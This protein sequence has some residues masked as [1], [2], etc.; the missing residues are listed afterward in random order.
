ITHRWAAPVSYSTDGMPVV[1]EVR[2]GVWAAGAYSGTGN[3]VGALCG[4]AVAQLVTRGTS[5]LL[6]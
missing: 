6:L 2:P 5:D 3:V 1:E 4:R